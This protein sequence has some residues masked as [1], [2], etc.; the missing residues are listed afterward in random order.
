MIEYATK[1]GTKLL[2]FDAE[3]MKGK[4]YQECIISGLNLPKYPDLD[5]RELCLHVLHTPFQDEFSWPI[6]IYERQA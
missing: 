3:R 4:V 5:T 2:C 1:T 6:S